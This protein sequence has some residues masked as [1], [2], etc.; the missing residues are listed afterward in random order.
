MSGH[1]RGRSNFHDALDALGEYKPRYSGLFLIINSGNRSILKNSV[2]QMFSMCDI[3]CI[4]RY[5]PNS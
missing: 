1:S 3:S 5:P 2:P 4:T